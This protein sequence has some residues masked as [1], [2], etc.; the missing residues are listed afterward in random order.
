MPFKSKS[1]LRTCYSK[2]AKSQK[3]QSTRYSKTKGW[4]CDKWLLETQSVCCLPEK[5]GMPI[6]SRCMRKGERVIGRVQTGIRGGKYF[7]IEE[8]DSKGTI[9]VTKV[10]IPR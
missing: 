4:D 2:Q 9:C 8:K 1:Q 6:K 10:Y 3:L 7:T 5:K